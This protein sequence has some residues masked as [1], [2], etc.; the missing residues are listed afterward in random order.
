MPDV[1]DLVW[2]FE[3]EVK[4]GTN[5]EEGEVKTKFEK[6]KPVDLDT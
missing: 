6:G 1:E 2:I 4:L 5:L 3:S